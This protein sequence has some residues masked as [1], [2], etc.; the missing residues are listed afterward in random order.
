MVRWPALVV[1]SAVL[2]GCG[3]N[4]PPPWH[5]EAGYRWRDLDVEPGSPGFTQ[6]AGWRSGIR[7]K[8]EVSEAALLGNRILGQG[9]GVALGDVDG[10]GHVD[11][12]LA[13]TEG[14]SALYRNKGDWKFEDVTKAAGVGACD[15]NSTGAAF[16]DVDGDRDLDLLLV[17]TRGPNAV[18][19]NDGRG[20]FAERRDAGLDTVGKGGTTLALADVDGDGRLDLYVANYKP[21]NVDDSIPP[22]QRAFNQMVQQ[23]APG[24]YEVVGEHQRDYKVVTRPDMGGIRLT[25]RGAPDDFYHNIGG[26]FERV[27][28]TGGRFLDATGR[29]L[30]EE[31]ESFGLGAK[32]SDLNGDGAPDLYV[33]NDFED[34]DEL[35]FNDGKGSFR[36][37]DWRAQRQMSNSSMGVDIADVNGDTLPDVLVVDMLSN[38]SR[39]LKTQI[40]TH[41]AF[42]KR[43]GD[44]TTTL[45][46]Q[47][48]TLYANRGDG[49]FA[50]VAQSAGVSASGWSWGTMFTDVD[51]DGWPDILIA[52]GHLWDTMDADVQERLQNRLTDIGWQRLRWQFPRLP[53]KNVAFRNTGRMTFT[54][55]STAWRFGTE[56]DISHGIASA[57]LDGDGDQDVVVNR[58]GATALVLRSESSAPR[59]AVRLIGD[60]PNT[61]AVGAKIKLIGGAQPIQMREVTAGGLYLSHSD[62]SASFAMGRSDNATIEVEWRDGARTVLRNVKP[63]RLY[64]VTTATAATPAPVEPTPIATLFEDASNALAG[65]V[66]RD[67]VFDDWV[68]QLLLPNALS[69]LGPGVTW[70]D[71]DRDG[72]DDLMVGAGRTGALA[73]FRNDRGRLTPLKS[74]PPAVADL[75]TILG[76]P[77]ADNRGS[78]LIAGSSNWEGQDVPGAI[79]F[80]ASRTDVVPLADTVAGS[81]PFAVGPMALGDYDGDGDLDLFVGGRAIARAYP[82]PASSLLYRNDGGRFTVDE[83]ASAQFRD[84]GLVSSA[85]FADVNSDGKADLA[86][87]REWGALQL[88]LNQGGQLRLA[89]DSWGLSPW[90]GRWNG[91]AAGDIDGDGRMDLIA[92]NWGRNT[93]LPADSTN[94]LVLIRGRFGAAGEEEL[95]TARRDDRIS[96]LAPLNSYPRVRAVIRDLPGRLSTFAAYADASVDVVLG[97]AKAVVHTS[98]IITNDHMAFMNRGDRFVAAPLPAEAQLSPAFYAGVADFDGDGAEDVFLAQNFSA[99]AVG[100]PR[101]DAGRGLLLTGDGLGGLAPMP[102]ARS[103]VVIYGDQRGAAYSDY[104]GDGRLDL[105]VSQNAGATKLFTNR[106]ARPGLRVRLVGT[107]ANPDAVGAQIR[108]VYGAGMS[109]VREVQAG[110]GYWSS[111]GAVQVF[112]LRGTATEVLVRWPGGVETRTRVVPGSREVV[113]RAPAP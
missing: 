21:Y 24:K 95:L 39:R 3:G 98:S 53:L 34:L 87:A 26:R 22:Q 80:R 101:Y 99:T 13:R 108:L 46:Q 31:P 50:E 9:A 8:N 55:A 23:T 86:L 10:D 38:D 76:L 107:T 1:L 41:T 71:Y 79:A 84:V 63:N 14:C 49:T 18:F 19:V 65:H 42:A 6:L 64:E 11:I 43:P 12:F 106:G 25:V 16:A 32:L 47:R 17:A 4:P 93:A 109:P 111:N 70:F 100:L 92:T 91:I 110:S 102:G 20:V 78:R 89:P 54:D 29:P 52:N 28:L 60:T 74:P 90:T 30:T 44:I 77:S 36:L 81:L 103:G 72:N 105:A 51:L 7:F 45:Q 82:A 104:N 94:P 67:T 62:Y 15:R 40:P 57:D 112:G 75:T 88:Y 113:V 5:Q 59:V 33:A 37:A 61:Q 58:L 2:L 69:Q 96:D 66:H 73:V 27:P 68:T 83:A 85:M 97:A 56:E 48:N 35:W